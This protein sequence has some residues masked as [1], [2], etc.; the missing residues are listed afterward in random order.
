[1][2]GDLDET[3]APELESWVESANE[4]DCDFPIQNLPFGRFRSAGQTHWRIGVAIGSQLLDLQRT[5]LI[6]TQDM[7]RL[8]EQSGA[9]RHAL[10]LALSRGLRRHSPHQLY[11]HAA[12]LPQAAVQMGLPCEIGD[13][14]DFYTGIHHATAVGK[15][16]RPDAPLLPNY[17]WVPVAYHGRA[18]SIGVSGHGFHR[19][20]GQIK[21]PNTEQPVCGPCQQL[22]FELELGVVIGHS[23]AMGMAVPI[24]EALGHVFGLVL[25]ND[26]SARDIQAWEY[27][28][29]GPFLS[30][31]F[32]STVSPWMVTLE[33]LSPFRRAFF[34]PSGDPAPLPYL[35]SP[36]NRLNGALDIELEVCLQTA[37][38]RAA[39][40]A[41]DPLARSNFAD[42][43]YWTV[44]QMV[45]HHTVNG[46]NLS[47]GDLFGTGTL[48]GANAGQ[49]GSLLEKTQ[50]GKK[51]ISLSNGETRTFLED[52]DSVTLRAYC[53]RGDFRRIGFGSCRATLLPAKPVKRN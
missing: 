24:S 4:K 28:P 13:Y 10:R 38:M 11:W 51:P 53:K 2:N 29:L 40:H 48:S 45:A 30:K 42:A 47:S 14:T 34:R 8:M 12:L 33:A 19:P 18:S 1:M 41:G 52:G 15:L 3:H 49:E 44:A 17:K 7:H 9:A 22:D 27:Q 5:G 36:G 26:W 32:A 16:F 21:L 23:N 20:C 31:N 25:F 39:G 6:D 43:A 50:G 37:A 35:D 46:C